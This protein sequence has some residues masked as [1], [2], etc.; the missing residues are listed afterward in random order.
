M[1]KCGIIVFIVS[2]LLLRMGR[3]YA[4]TPHLLRQMVRNW[5]LA[6][7]ATGVHWVFYDLYNAEED[8][9]DENDP[10]SDTTIGPTSIRWRVNTGNF[11]T[12]WGNGDTCI[13]LGSWD[14]TYAA[15]PGTYGGNINHKGYYWLFSDTLVDTTATETW[16]PDDTLRQIPKPIVTKTGPGGG[17]N[18]TIWV[19]IP[20]PMET[21]R[22]E[23]TEYDVLGY[24]LWADSS[25]TGT[26]NA[27]NAASAMEIAFITVSGVYGDTTVF[28]M[29]ESDGFEGWSTWTTYFAYKIVA[30]PDTVNAPADTM[31][32]STYYFSQNSD[33]IHVYQ[34]VVDIKENT[35]PRIQQI[36]LQALPS[37]FCDNTR[38]VFSITKSALV[39]LVVYNTTGQIIR[40]LVNDVKPAGDH[41]IEFDG[42]DT[43]GIELPAGIYFYQLQT[44]E[45]Q[46]TG[47]LTKLR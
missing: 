22:A 31:G 14:S 37:I 19:K 16:A 7:N 15:S 23:Q 26:P 25:G 18:D 27:F 42:I 35:Q 10:G 28:W 1:K 17:A 44:S 21:R 34:N 45:Q 36:R 24:W 11:P 33:S 38:I 5:P 8:W 39:K 32:Y 9:L 43:Q 3:L 12:P 2:A 6:N 29:L 40:T 13:C 20:N 47:R 4:G 46:L 30:R 41:H